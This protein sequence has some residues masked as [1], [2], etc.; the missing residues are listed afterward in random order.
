MTETTKS[1][2]YTPPNMT[3]QIKEWQRQERLVPMARPFGVRLPCKWIRPLRDLFVACWYKKKADSILGKDSDGVGK[4]RIKDREYCR[5]EVNDMPDCWEG[6]KQSCIDRCIHYLRGTS[7]YNK[8]N[9]YCDKQCENFELFKGRINNE[10]SKVIDW[11]DEKNVKYT[12]PL[13]YISQV[14]EINKLG[15]EGLSA[16]EICMYM[17]NKYGVN[18][19]KN[20]GTN[21]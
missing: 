8:L 20:N 6:L 21:K 7:R 5:G 4:L 12:K 13:P 14:D 2:K 18:E 19:A 11:C 10:R 17:D 15:K 3:K 9:G 1:K 16:N